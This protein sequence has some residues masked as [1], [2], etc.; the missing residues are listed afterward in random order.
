MC[1]LQISIE[2]EEMSGFLNIDD[3]NNKKYCVVMLEDIDEVLETM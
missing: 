3:A 1:T 2:Q